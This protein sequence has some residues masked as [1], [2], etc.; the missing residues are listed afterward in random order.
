MRPQLARL[1]LGDDPGRRAI[2]END[3]VDHDRPFYRARSGKRRPTQ[4]P[5]QRN[6]PMIFLFNL[7]LTG[8]SGSAPC[9]A[10]GRGGFTLIE[11]IL[12]LAACAVLMAAVYGVFSKAIHLRN[13]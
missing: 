6:P 2:R 5:R 1:S 3:H 4:H 12:A 11:L 8:P 13:E 7:K 10:R 9:Q